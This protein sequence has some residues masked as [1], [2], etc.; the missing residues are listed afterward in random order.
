MDDHRY[1]RD[2]P[3]ARLERQNTGIYWQVRLRPARFWRGPLHDHVARRQD[4]VRWRHGQQRRQKAPARE[5][6]ILI[7]VGAFPESHRIHRL[8]DPSSSKVST[9]SAI[10][11]LEGDLHAA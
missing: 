5:L 3:Q 1:G 9:I 6:T 2:D 7:H 10:L 4:Y 8:A 11:R